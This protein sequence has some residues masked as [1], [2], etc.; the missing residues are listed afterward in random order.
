MGDPSQIDVVAVAEDLAQQFAA[1]AATR[2]R[3]GGSAP[4]ELDLIRQSGLLLL[5]VPREYGGLGA[6]WTDTLRAVCAIARADTSLAHIFSWHQLEVVTPTMIGTPA[7]RDYY[8]RETAAQGWFWGSALNPLDSRATATRDGRTLRINGTKSF[9]T[10]ARG[11]DML[12]VGAVEPGTPG[13]L[14]MAVP[15]SRAGVTVNDD[16]DNMGQRQSDSGSVTLTDVEVDE[17]EVLGRVRVAPTPRLALRTC[18]SQIMFANMFVGLAEGALAEAKQ[19]TLTQTRPWPGTKVE[20]A[21]DEPTILHV[22]GELWTHVRAAALLADDAAVR[23]EEAWAPI[24]ATTAGADQSPGGVSERRFG[25]EPQAEAVKACLVA[26]DAAKVLATEVGLDVTSRMFEVMGARAT[27]GRFN[28]DRHWR[29]IR[30]LTL[31]DPVEMRLREL[32][33]WYL[34]DRLPVPD[35]TT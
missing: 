10:G 5:R 12:L 34:N 24:E 16:W 7:Q 19:Y 30:T 4:T 26:V 27:A 6:S 33:D 29:N 8:Y 17:D 9:C 14:A 35:V 18:L 25:G 15:T 21:A 22:Y 32:G 23:L 31:H 28:Y 13:V 3:Q 1:T 2:E 20:R 11:S